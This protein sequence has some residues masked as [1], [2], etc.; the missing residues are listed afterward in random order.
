[1]NTLICMGITAQ[2]QQGP[3]ENLS[4]F[5]CSMARVTRSWS[6]LSDICL[7]SSQGSPV[8]EP[9]QL[10][11]AD[12]FQSYTTLSITKTLMV[13]YLNL[14]A[15]SNQLLL[16]L[17]TTGIVNYF[18]LPFSSLLY[19]WTML[20]ASSVCFNLNDLSTFLYRLWF[21]DFFIALLRILLSWNTSF[22]KDNAW[23]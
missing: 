21:P 15:N 3:Q 12:L 5:L 10:P 2:D 8:P 17:S 14:H 4:G 6:F 9:Q 22:L 18:I 16:T 19:I 23:N 13:P 20:R 11:Q 7:S 1:M